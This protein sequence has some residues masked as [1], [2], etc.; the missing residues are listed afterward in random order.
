MNAPR[1]Y[2]IVNERRTM[3]TSTF[4]L[5]T[6]NIYKSLVSMRDV[7]FYTASNLAGANL[8]ALCRILDVLTGR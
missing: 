3:F 2:F 8:L 6:D 7:Y 1:G 4:F 5:I